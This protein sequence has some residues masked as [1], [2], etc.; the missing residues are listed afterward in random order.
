MM[1]INDLI[2]ENGGT[3]GIRQIRSTKAGLMRELKH[4]KIQICSDTFEL[5]HYLVPQIPLIITNTCLFQLKSSSK[6]KRRYIYHTIEHSGIP[7]LALADSVG[8]PEDFGRFSEIKN[9]PVFTSIYGEHLLESRMLS[10]LR[11]K[12]EHIVTLH[13]NLVDGD[14]AGILIRGKSDI[15]KTRFVARLVEQG[16]RWVADDC[17]EIEKRE[18]NVLIG[19]P[20][21]RIANLMELKPF[22]VVTITDFFGATSLCKES[23]ITLILDL[24]KKPFKKNGTILSRC[25]H[26]IMGVKLPLIKIAVSHDT[27]GIADHID[28]YRR[29]A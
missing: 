20:H 22:G 28:S 26:T 25:V 24:Q 3:L 2:E 21:E 15:G 12:I 18:G 14:G 4:A 27:R 23:R 19:R 29:A 10:L 13:G 8:I 17:V 6:I 9:L 5:I 11:E 16:Y 1:T 7:C